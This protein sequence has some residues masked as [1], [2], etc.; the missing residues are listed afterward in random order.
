MESLFTGFDSIPANQ[1]MYLLSGTLLILA[2]GIN[3]YFW[4]RTPTGIPRRL[5]VGL[6]LM[7]LV[8]MAAF[9]AASL[10]GIDSQ[11]ANTWLPPIDRFQMAFILIWLLW[12]WAFPDASLWADILT[13][14]L[15]L[16]IMAVLTVS[17]NI[18][19]ASAA[20]ASFN[21]HW[22][23]FIWQGFCLVYSI[24][25]L[26]ILYIQRKRLWGAGILTGLLFLI[27]H[28]LQ[29]TLPNLT[30]SYSVPVRLATLIALPI[31]LILPQGC[32]TPASATHAAALRHGRDKRDRRRFSTE[33]PTALGFLSLVWEDTPQTAMHLLVKSIGRAL[34]A[35]ICLFTTSPNQNNQVTVLVGHDFYNQVDIK[36]FKLDRQRIPRVVEALN[37]AHTL[38]LSED[39]SD[40][41]DAAYICRM[42][43]FSGTA[44]LLFH[45]VSKPNA[46]QIGGILLLAPYSRRA[47]TE[48]DS[49]YVAGLTE[50]LLRIIEHKQVQLDAAIQNQKLTDEQRDSSRTIIDLQNELQGLSIELE[51]FQNR[52]AEFET[53]QNKKLSFINPGSADE[54]VQPRRGQTRDATVRLNPLVVEKHDSQKEINQLKEENDA[55]RQ[56]IA[57][58]SA[59]PEEIDGRP[60]SQAERELRSSLEE[61]AR[62]KNM[63]ANADMKLRQLERRVQGGA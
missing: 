43:R 48:D 41:P 33:L 37:K 58:I 54:P 60:M 56:L 31:L 1:I 4:R 30:T 9:I 3:H 39:Y 10:V 57:H 6:L 40:T 25:I 46:W 59:G 12:I 62:L 32:P 11:T 24:V 15:T 5:V 18:W 14:I 22:L 55:L 26:I 61:V 51:K 23:D 20:G 16:G 42:V 44:P 63:L 7:M 27:A 49:R 53:N 45:P 17:L 2:L 8:E 28:A 47:W 50:A 35:D 38:R 34:L 21:A 36:E 19:P 13:V 52:I 29:L